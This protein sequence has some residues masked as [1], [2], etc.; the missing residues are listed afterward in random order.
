MVG[1]LVEYLIQNAPGDG[2][3]VLRNGAPIGRRRVLE[4]AVD[5]AGRFAESEAL[6]GRATR[7]VMERKPASRLSDV[8]CWRCAA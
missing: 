4:H 6:Q 2:W 5:F 1:R 8:A 3:T 7:V